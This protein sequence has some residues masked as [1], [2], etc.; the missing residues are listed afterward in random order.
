MKDMVPRVCASCKVLRERERFPRMPNG[1]R[2]KVCQLCIDKAQAPRACRGCATLT[3]LAHY[4]LRRDGKPSSLCSAC[5]VAKAKKKCTGCKENKDRSQF[6][7]YSNSSR[8]RTCDTCRIHNSSVKKCLKCERTLPRTEFHRYA[9]HNCA[10]SCNKCRRADARRGQPQHK[11][12][13]PCAACG[14]PITR[15]MSPSRLATRKTCSRVCSYRIRNTQVRGCRRCKKKLP[16]TDFDRLKDSPN[17]RSSCR[18]CIKKDTE[19]VNGKPKLRCSLTQFRANLTAYARRCGVS[20]SLTRHQAKAIYDGPCELCGK[21]V[22]TVYLRD[23]ALGLVMS[24]CRPI[25][26]PCRLL[27]NTFTWPELVLLANE[28]ASRNRL[29]G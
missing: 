10:D 1:D 21:T 12:P 24:N 9:G 6:F 26:R 4:P 16:Y 25:C 2:G 14:G 7:L 28:I 17:K 18:A 15:A 5:H 27:L 20:F 19:L 8:S 13:H 11:A 22:S 29:D 23:K 3:Q